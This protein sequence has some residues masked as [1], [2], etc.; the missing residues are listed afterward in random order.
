MTK[1]HGTAVGI[2]TRITPVAATSTRKA[3]TSVDIEMAPEERSG[4]GYKERVAIRSV[5]EPPSRC[6]VG[7]I[8]S[9]SGELSAST[10][11]AK[12]KWYARLSIYG[13]IEVVDDAPQG[14]S[15]ASTNQLLPQQA[16]PKQTTD[17]RPPAAKEQP[18]ANSPALPLS[19]EDTSEV[20]F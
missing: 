10:F 11:E 8:V 1:I 17:Y 6:Q 19:E 3:F 7:A 15:V 9:V 2:V 18:V 12:G 13:R 16:Y 20:P 5:G 4:K 14:N